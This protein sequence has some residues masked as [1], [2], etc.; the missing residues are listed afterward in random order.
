MTGCVAVER[1]ALETMTVRDNRPSAMIDQRVRG[2]GLNNWDLSFLKEFPVKEKLRMQFRWEMFNAFN[3]T[4]FQSMDAVARFDAAGN[5]VN[6][7][8]GSLI[9]ATPARKMQGSLRISF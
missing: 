3:H 4:Q 9:D 7:R 8:F 2:A 1:R 6:P 5:Q